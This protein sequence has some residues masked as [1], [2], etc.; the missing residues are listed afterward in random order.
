MTGKDTKARTLICT[1][2]QIKITDDLLMNWLL[3]GNHNKVIF[4][5]TRQ[6]AGSQIFIQTLIKMYFAFLNKR[7]CST[8]HYA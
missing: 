3:S 7:S 8:S 2:E 5:L 1:A 6:N 4:S